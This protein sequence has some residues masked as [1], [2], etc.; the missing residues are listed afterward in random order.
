MSQRI[1]PLF[2]RSNVIAMSFYELV[3]SIDGCEKSETINVGSAS[4]LVVASK[5]LD[6]LSKRGC[7]MGHFKDD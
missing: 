4:G 3:V 7:K 1:A 6:E 5:F 2:S